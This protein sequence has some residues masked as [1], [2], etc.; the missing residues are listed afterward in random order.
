MAKAILVG[1]FA[2]VAALVGAAVEPPADVLKGPK[3]RESITTP[4]SRLGFDGQLKKLERRPE[5][6]A[7]VA[8]ELSPDVA[9][10]AMRVISK[11]GLLL[12]KFIAENLDLVTKIGVAGGA[13]NKLDVLTLLWE[14]LA[15]LQA[16]GFDGDLEGQI[17]AV[18]PED[19]R[20]EFAGRIRAQWRQAAAQKLHKPVD[21]ITR[22]EAFAAR[23]AESGE[24]LGFE[25]EQAFKRS[26]S[27]GQLAFYYVTNGL[28]LS[29]TQM[30][31]LRSMFDDF[32]E[33]IGGEPTEEQR[34]KFLGGLLAYL[35]PQQQETL[36]KRFRGE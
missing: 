5:E 35:T 30:D 9:D 21:K 3:V 24:L 17:S 34:N 33:S 1:L 10:R 13:Q 19:R 27:S 20:S 14:A 25:F 23:A 16:M 8:M 26:E 32:T 6:T 22:G 12:Q 18:L 15:R 36:L 2:G 4:L 29:Q 7:L 31:T 28:G 11:R